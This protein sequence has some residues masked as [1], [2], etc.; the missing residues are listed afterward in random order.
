MCLQ[1]RDPPW[2]SCAVRQP[3]GTL[4]CAPLLL[5]SPRKISDLWQTDVLYQI[6]LRYFKG[7]E[8]DYFEVLKIRFCS[9]AYHILLETRKNAS[10]R[11]SYKFLVTKLYSSQTHTSF[12][13]TQIWL[14][15]VY[16]TG[17]AFISYLIYLL[18]SFCYTFVYIY[19]YIYMGG[20]WVAQS[21]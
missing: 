18:S 11:V 4:S 3:S 20:G 13:L 5:T 21:V 9:S 8:W 17:F 14:H 15:F 19:I 10:W 12:H 2:E 16:I 7:N 6:T 1:Q